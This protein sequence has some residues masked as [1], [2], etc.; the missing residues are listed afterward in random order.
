MKTLAQIFAAHKNPVS[1]KG[2]ELEAMP[3]AQ[4]L[5]YL[6]KRKKSKMGNVP[7]VIDGILFQSTGEGNFYKELKL[8]LLA[9]DIKE[10]KRQ[11]PFDFFVSGVKVAKYIAD[12]VVINNDGS[13][14]VLD[15]KS[16]ATAKLQSYQRAKKLMLACYGVEVKEVYKPSRKFVK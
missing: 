4:L 2:K 7:I 10:F 1:K 16:P 3:P 12:F 8:R 5:A 9:G 14:D 6:S 13:I 11:V 15:Y